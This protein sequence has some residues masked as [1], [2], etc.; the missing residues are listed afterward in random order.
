M[1][2]HFLSDFKILKMRKRTNE[3]LFRRWHL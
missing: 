1:K 3:K 2:Y